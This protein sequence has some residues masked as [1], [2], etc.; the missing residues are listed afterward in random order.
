MGTDGIMDQFILDQAGESAEGIYLTTIGSPINELQDEGADFY[1]NYV[2]EYGIEP[3]TYSAFG[4][5]AAKVSLLAIDRA[6]QK[7]REKVLGELAG[8]RDFPGIFGNWSFN[9]SGD[10]DLILVSGNIVRDGKFE[11]EKTLS[12]GNN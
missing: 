8:L 2:S 7:N 5:E 10:T 3:N 11:Y 9:S 6:G 12:S 1:K 4:Y